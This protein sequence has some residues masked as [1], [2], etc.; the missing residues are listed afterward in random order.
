MLTHDECLAVFALRAIHT[1]R[2]TDAVMTANE[3]LGFLTKSAPS[4][5]FTVRAL[6]APRI[7]RVSS[8]LSLQVTELCVEVSKC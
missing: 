5:A 8:K 3:A 4:T 7:G 1:A 2:T 6:D